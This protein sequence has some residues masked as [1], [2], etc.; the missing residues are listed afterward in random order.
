MNSLTFE[1]RLNKALLEAGEWLGW[2]DQPTG[3]ADSSNPQPSGQKAPRRAEISKSNTTISP[4]QNTSLDANDMHIETAIG[5]IRSAAKYV[6]SP[7]FKNKEEVDGLLHKI[8]NAAAEMVKAG[9]PTPKVH[10]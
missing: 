5:I 6:G 9:V 2:P 4:T 1:Q 7:R 3:F 10:A 8:Y